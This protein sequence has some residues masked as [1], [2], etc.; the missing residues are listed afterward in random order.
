MLSLEIQQLKM[1]KTDSVDLVKPLKQFV[2]KQY[3]EGV[4]REYET[5]LQNLQQKRNQLLNLQERSE[6]SKDLCLKYSAELDFIAKHF[7]V[8]SGAPRVTH[9]VPSP[10]ITLT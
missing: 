1:K 7:P 9:I 2:T 4:A 3:G 10:T 5:S 6:G 8:N